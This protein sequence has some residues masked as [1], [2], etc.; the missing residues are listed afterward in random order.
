MATVVIQVATA[1]LFVSFAQHPHVLAHT[2][3]K[4][5]R[6]I[7]TDGSLVH[8]FFQFVIGDA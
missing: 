7:F 8:Y 4:V 2:Q 3:P 6:L 1:T 5:I